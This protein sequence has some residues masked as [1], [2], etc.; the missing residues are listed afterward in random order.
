MGRAASVRSIEAIDA[1]AA[2]LRRFREEVS[3]A[4]ADLD[5]EAGRALEWIGHDRPGYWKREVRLGWDRVGEARGNI[6]RA[7]TYRSVAEVEPACREEKAALDQ[8]K[9][10]LAIAI[11]KDKAVRHWANQ[12]DRATIEMRGDA[13][14]LARLVEIDLPQAL[15]A[16][17]RMGT[18]LRSYV[19]REL[20]VDAATPA[21]VPAPSAAAVEDSQE[22]DE[23]DVP[24]QSGQATENAPD[25]PAADDSDA[26]RAGRAE[27]AE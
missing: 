18:A 21:G 3:A 23:G 8:A 15:A 11:D 25:D 10:R 16:L 7:K 5:L 22:A 1:F 4:L 20:A 17:Q 12:V 27:E 26:D 13:N 9:R 6:E 19:E 24:E 14:Q 2:A